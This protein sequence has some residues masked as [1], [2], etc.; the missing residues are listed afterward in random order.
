LLLLLEAVTPLRWVD[1]VFG[2]TDGWW[3]FTDQ[4]LRSGHPLLSLPG[5]RSLVGEFG[6]A[7]VRELSGQAEA[8]VKNSV[9]MARGPRVIAVGPEEGSEEP[10]E[11]GSWVIFTDQG[12]YGARLAKLLEQRNQTCKLIHETS[13]GL[14]GSGSN[15]EARGHLSGGVPADCRTLLLDV[16]S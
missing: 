8:D 5:W 10:R 16:L 4:N 13:P 7:D 6:F 9:I 11:P 15:G 12:G 14:P 3:K 2:L 1:M